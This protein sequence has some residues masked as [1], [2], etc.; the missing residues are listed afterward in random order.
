LVRW[1]EWKKVTTSVTS[2]QAQPLSFFPPTE[3][4]VR[5]CRCL[6][7]ERDEEQTDVWAVE[8]VFVLVFV[9]VVVVAFVAVFVVVFVVVVV[10]VVF[11]I[12]FGK[13]ENKEGNERERVHEWTDGKGR[14]GSPSRS[15]SSLREERKGTSKRERERECTFG[16]VNES[17]E[18]RKKERYLGIKYVRAE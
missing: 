1:K 6:A 10:V 8:I 7:G 5:F 17:R 18:R 12:V 16:R 13:E 4:R 9:V 3:E 2:P 11:V 14:E 15:L